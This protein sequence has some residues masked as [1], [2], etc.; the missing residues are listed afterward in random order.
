M[1]E[2]MHGSINHGDGYVEINGWMHGWVDA[3]M[4]GDGYV[5][6]DE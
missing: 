2:W 1:D 4:H 6:I 5:E 3:R